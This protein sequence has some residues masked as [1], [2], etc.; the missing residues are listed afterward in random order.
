MQQIQT[1]L[2]LFAQVGEIG[3]VNLGAQYMHVC[4]VLIHLRWNGEFRIG[5]HVD[6]PV[7]GT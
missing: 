3:R 6:S 1:N 7:H 4:Q 5:R 2:Q